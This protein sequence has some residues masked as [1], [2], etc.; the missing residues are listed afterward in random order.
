MAIRGPF[1]IPR[2]GWFYWHWEGL[3]SFGRNNIRM[4]FPGAC[5]WHNRPRRRL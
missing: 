5:M 3:C 2:R 1:I 4:N